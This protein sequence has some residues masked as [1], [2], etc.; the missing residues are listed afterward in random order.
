MKMI[1]FFIVILLL[2]VT[3]CGFH[4]RGYEA[5]PP[6]L[7]HLYIQSNNPYSPLT[8]QLQQ[9]LRSSGIV[10]SS[11]A[12][13]A[14]VTLKVLGDDNGRQITSQGVSGQLATYMLSYS[15]TYQLIG[16]DGHVIQEPQT[17]TTTRNY[18]VSANQILG[19]LSVEQNLQNEMRRDVI[20]QLIQRLYS[21]NT[22][23][24]L[25]HLK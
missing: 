11:T 20:N 5:L 3:G 12:Q 22:S 1:R 16:N 19:D 2:S 23:Q 7:Q 8:K 25:S 24:A 18:V 6:Q 9:M 17:I 4:M 10:I 21:K 14:S 13:A 15:V